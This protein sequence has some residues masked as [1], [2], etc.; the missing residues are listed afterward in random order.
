MEGLESFSTK[1]VNQL[2]NP[3]IY[4]FHYNLCS[5]GNFTPSIVSYG[6]NNEILVGNHALNYPDLSR[7]LYGLYSLARNP[8]G[9]K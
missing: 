5:G 9:E 6:D 8:G 1:K 7:V 3:L 4:S 2:W